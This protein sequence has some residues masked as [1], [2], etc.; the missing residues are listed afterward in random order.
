[1]SELINFQLKESTVKPPISDHSNCQA[2]LVFMGGDHLRE[3]R[4]YGV[5]ILPH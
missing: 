3:C 2:E 1:M 5:K 4:P